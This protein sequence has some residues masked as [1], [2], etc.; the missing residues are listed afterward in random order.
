[1]TASATSSAITLLMPTVDA[2][3]P[4]S[5]SVA[6]AAPGAGGEAFHQIFAQVADVARAGV[7]LLSPTAP[8]SV[9]AEPAAMKDGSV[10]PPTGL[11]LP[12]L[13]AETVKTT[14][15]DDDISQQLDDEENATDSAA[16]GVLLL[17]LPIAAPVQAVESAKAGEGGLASSATPQA[18]IAAARAAT[19]GTAES[20]TGETTAEI[21]ST[22]PAEGKS[23]DRVLLGHG[24]NS[25]GGA[26]THAGLQEMRINAAADPATGKSGN[27]DFE[28]L[29]KQLDSAETTTSGDAA[30]P[31]SG[32]DSSRLVTNTTR[33]HAQG[34]TPATATVSVPIGADGWS[35]AVTDK[36]MWFS[37][38]KIASAEIHLNPPDLGPLQ[39]RISTQQD[40]TTVTFSSQHAAVREVLDQNLP[41]LR[42]MLGNQGL[43]LADAGVGNQDGARQQNARGHGEGQSQ[44]GARDVFGTEPD[45]Q[46][47]AVTSV[48]AGRI[49]RSAIDAYA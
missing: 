38:S 39:V 3:T 14:E 11:L 15:A 25:E 18:M 46:P 8:P 31:A 49:A 34:Q 21:E 2:S 28:A 4:A 47:V 19:N 43:Q 40:Q 16:S 13:T 20:S 9:S 42:E 41:R 1:M 36:V 10:L 22:A 45:A 35:D 23:V 7:S 5:S 33:T 26:S 37:A 27:A 30:A 24:S 12:P 6:D 32:V 29:V 48:V 44:Q 17:G